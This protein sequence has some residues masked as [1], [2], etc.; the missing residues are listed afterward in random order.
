MK[1][2][3]LSDSYS[4]GDSFMMEARI[5]TRKWKHYDL[6]TVVARDDKKAGRFTGTTRHVEGNEAK[7]LEGAGGR[8]RFDSMSSEESTAMT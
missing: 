2:L 5:P 8:R 4:P 7:E 3:C 1:V 6:A